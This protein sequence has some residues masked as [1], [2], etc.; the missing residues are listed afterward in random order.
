MLRTTSSGRYTMPRPLY[1]VVVLATAACAPA[2]PTASRPV[3]AA[4]ETATLPEVRTGMIFGF[5]EPWLERQDG[6][7][8]L[9][10]DTTRLEPMPVFRPDTTI[11]RAMV[12]R[13]GGSTVRVRLRG[14]AKV[15]PVNPSTDSLVHSAPRP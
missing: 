2:A 10:P 6:M 5:R 8:V 13:G 11:D 1:L 3:P 14:P 9:R 12:V 15:V 7:P 4:A